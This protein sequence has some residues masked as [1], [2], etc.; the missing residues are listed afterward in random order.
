MSVVDAS[1]WDA[2]N[3]MLG[4]YPTSVTLGSDEAVLLAAE[5]ACPTPRPPV[6]RDGRSRYRLPDPDDGMKV[7]SWARVSTLGKV[8][9]DEY[10]LTLWKLRMTAMGLARRPDLLA[11][12]AEV[13]AVAPKNHK[14]D[15]A[16][17]N[18]KGTISHALD[19]AAEEAGAGLRARVGTALHTFTEHHDLGTGVTAPPPWD[20]DVEA[21]AAALDALSIVRPAEWVERIVLNPAVRSA[22]TLDRIVTWDHVGRAWPGAAWV[23]PR[24]GDLKTGDDLRFSQI[25][26]SIQ[27]ATYARAPWMWN[28]VTG[29]LEPMPAVDLKTALVFHLPAKSAKCDV[30]EVDIEAGWELAQVCHD[31]RVARRRKDYFTLIE[32]PAPVEAAVTVERGVAAVDTPDIAKYSDDPTVLLVAELAMLAEHAPF[33]VAAAL[34][35][36][37]FDMEAS[38][39]TVAAVADLRTVLAPFMVIEDVP[40]PY[41]D[42]TLDRLK[43][44]A[45]DIAERDDITVTEAVEQVAATLTPDP[46][47]TTTAEDA[48]HAACVDPWCASRHKCS[49]P[50]LCRSPGGP[51]MVRNPPTVDPSTGEVERPV[52]YPNPRP[53]TVLVCGSR[54]W[55]DA[56]AMQ[57]RLAAYVGDRGPSNVEVVTGGAAGADTMGHLLAVKLGTH[58]TVMPADWDQHGKRAGFVRNE[59]MVDVLEARRAA[60]VD[61]GVE[62]FSHGTRGTQHTINLAR[63]RGLWVHVEG[64][65]VGQEPVTPPS[66]PPQ[67]PAAIAPTD[68]SAW[69]L[70]RLTAIQAGRGAAAGMDAVMRLWPSGVPGAGPWT[71]EQ[72][73]AVLPAIIKGE[74]LAAAPFPEPD[75][76]HPLADPPTADPGFTRAHLAAVPDFTDLVDH[77]PDWDVG[78]GGVDLLPAT[79]EAVAKVKGTMAF[80][81]DT[82][83]ATARAWR[84]QGRDHGRPWETE[85]PTMRSCALVTAGLTLA[86]HLSEQAQPKGRRNVDWVRALISY[87]LDRRLDDA[88]STGA[89]IGSL[90]TDEAV[91]IANLAVEASKDLT[92]RSELLAHIDN[93]G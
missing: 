72:V 12:V 80:L 49:A 28:A 51:N 31:V 56:T 38:P 7:K 6:E 85:T 78:S 11:K 3:Q 84:N 23:A 26:I 18:H 32:L 4:V 47:F 79:D 67:P 63:S 89:V 36:I 73:E 8:I 17:Q 42:P 86:M 39:E 22:G 9:S 19:Q 10:A 71:D 35:S 61:V 87:V 40:L 14:G 57:A 25:E 93:G 82:Q 5:A 30:Y 68:R 13:D 53:V 29:R 48:L 1:S 70:E 92:V 62:A 74:R 16:G 45:Q 91:L 88:W 77:A 59:A 81:T 21:Y 52:T 41:D 24:I 2:A 55:N 50:F 69:M 15:I 34:D 43:Q 58:S 90:T 60:G 66:A 75:P 65:E 37:Q 33:E 83:D 46:P 44:Q 27:L 54:T 64:V 76:A 20:A